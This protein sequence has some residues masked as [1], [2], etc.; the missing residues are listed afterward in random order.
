MPEMVFRL[1]GLPAF[2][3]RAAVYRLGMP[4][5]DGPTFTGPGLVFLAPATGPP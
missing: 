5:P 1:P 3:T 4:K 2:L